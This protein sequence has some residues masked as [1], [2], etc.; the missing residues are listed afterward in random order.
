MIKRM[1]A[2]AGLVALAATLGCTTYTARMN[3]AGV[4]YYDGDF[5]RSREELDELV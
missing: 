3:D 2:L 1:T 4:C 5:D